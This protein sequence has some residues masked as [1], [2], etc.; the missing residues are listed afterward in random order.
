MTRN[1]KLKRNQWKYEDIININYL[2][3]NNMFI[4]RKI[5]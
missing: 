1:K 4:E 3:L 2:D 5:I